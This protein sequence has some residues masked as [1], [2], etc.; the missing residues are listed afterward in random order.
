[1]VISILDD[2]FSQRLS[3]FVCGF[4]LADKERVLFFFF[5]KVGITMTTFATEP[6]L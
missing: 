5:G 2:L 6:T 1:M 3:E 4:Q